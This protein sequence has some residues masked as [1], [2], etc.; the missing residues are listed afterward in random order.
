MNATLPVQRVASHSEDESEAEGGENGWEGI[1]EAVPELVDHEEEYVDE[2]KYTTVT[3][4]EV[5]IS[6]DGI[7]KIQGADEDGGE[8]P[9]TIKVPTLPAKPKKDSAR[10]TRDK[11]KKIKKK[12]KTF[13]YE[14]P[15]E[16]KMNRLKVREKNSKAAKARRGE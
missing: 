9:D 16:R 7:R 15:A 10:K 14:S 6:R 5:D 11:D 12:K 4:E 8:A 3:V 2:D 1:P 13:R